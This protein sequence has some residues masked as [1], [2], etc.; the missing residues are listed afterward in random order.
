MPNPTIIHTESSKIRHYL[1]IA[2]FY[3]QIGC[4]EIYEVEPQIAEDYVPDAY[5]RIDGTPILVEI[6]RSYI[7]NRKMQNKIDSWVRTYRE[8]KH[9]A[10]TL[11]V[12]SDLPFKVQVPNGFVLEFKELAKG[13]VG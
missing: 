9:D 7:S 5:T 8:G 6:Q 13:Q 10:R 12:V 11:W 4:P 3:I 1:A 2:D